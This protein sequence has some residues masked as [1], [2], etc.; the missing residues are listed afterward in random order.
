METESSLPHLQQ[1]ATV[2]NLCQINP[3]HAPIP[4]L[5]DQF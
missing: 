4:L 2:P 1:P 3:V 5:E